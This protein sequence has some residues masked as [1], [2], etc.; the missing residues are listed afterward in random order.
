M[1]KMNEKDMSLDELSYDLDDILKEFGS[2]DVDYSS[3]EEIE[4]ESG[5][6]HPIADI[7][8]EDDRISSFV[9]DEPQSDSPAEEGYDFD[10]N[11]IK[12]EFNSDFI[13]G[14]SEFSAEA[15]ILEFGS[16]P[17]PEEEIVPEPEEP[18]LELSEEEA[19]EEVPEI[20]PVSEPEYDLE[21]IIAEEKALA[22]QELEA[23]PEP[24][25]SEEAPAEEQP[26][27]DERTG[28]ADVDN[29]ASQDKLS[30]F[31]SRFK[32]SK[33]E[34]P[35]VTEA[36]PVEMPEASADEAVIEADSVEA[37]DVFTEETITYKVEKDDIVGEIIS[38]QTSDSEVSEAAYAENSDSISEVKA[39]GPAES[40]PNENRKTFRETVLNPI[41]AFAALIA[42]DIQQS[43]NILQSAHDDS[44]EDLGAEMAPDKAAKFYDSHIA[45]LRL[46]VRISF[47]ISLIM[48]YLSYGLPLFGAINDIGVRSAVCTVL[49]LA[50]MLLG[51]DIITSGIMSI[52]RRKPHANALIAI[53]ALLCV[54]DGIVASAGVKGNGLPFSAVPALTITFTLLGSVMNCRSNRIICNTAA[55]SKNPYT[56]TAE[57]S[58]SGDG[59]T[60]VKLHRPMKDIVRRT[61]EAGPDEEVYSLMTPYLII[62]SLFLGLVAAIACKNFAGIAH[63]LSGIFVCAAPVVMLLSFPLPFFVSI[64]GLIKTRSTVVGWSGLDDIGKGKHVIITDNDLFPKGT[65]N[66]G[67]I[68]YMTGFDPEYVVSLAGSII[69]ASKCSMAPAFT[70]LINK[71]NGTF[72]TVDNFRPHESGGLIAMIDGREVLCGDFAFMKLMG[73]TMHPAI[74]GRHNIY[75]AADN[76]LCGCFPIEYT[77]T[78]P[79]K[80]ALETIMRTK[81]HPI[82][83][84]RDFN[85]T[86]QMLSVKF[87]MATDGFDFPPFTERYAISE[88]APT[89]NSKPAALISREGLGPYVDLTEHCRSLYS[90]VRLNVLLSVLST[91]IGIILMFILFLTGSM[92]S[93]LMLTYMLIW[94]LAVI[95]ISFT[96]NTK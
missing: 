45:G 16:E 6:S 90:R 53:S 57:N 65:V 42:L 32:R 82:F 75:I 23:E 55:A 56:V 39:A 47:V 78:E 28:E 69:T 89:E 21:Q 31:F 8:D 15:I 91:V 68:R 33:K 2:V 37:P 35:A 10:A 38:E 25:K 81:R 41:V 85:I 50:V 92:T 66:I 44:D 13:E 95:F 4:I 72:L 86:P 60:L 5:I 29:G 1:D 70:D 87:D 76:V 74:I 18:E 36:V 14:D 63:I 83:A 11:D 80:K 84:V 9:I 20:V 30:A 43:K 24:D 58:V 61:E 88:T 3:V 94:L 77:A 7:S 40:V 19:P 46:R 52:V 48:I 64:K 54:I 27:E 12:A 26:A 34:A 93:G 96:T 59:I 49:L 22:E 67:R 17:A 79:V 51:L 62:A 73:V 71:G